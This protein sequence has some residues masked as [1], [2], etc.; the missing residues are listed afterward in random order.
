MSPAEV[1]RVPWWQRR[2]YIDGLNEE[3]AP[4]SEAEDG[5]DAKRAEPRSYRD[6][7]PEPETRV[8]TPEEEERVKRQHERYMKAAPVPGFGAADSSALEA[9]GFQVRKV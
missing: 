5:S 6:T 1:D 7:T 9:A 4:P 8:L 2:M 3:F